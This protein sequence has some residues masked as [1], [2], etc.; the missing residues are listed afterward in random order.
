MRRSA[1]FLLLLLAGCGGAG[2]YSKPGADESAAS[3]AYR[4]CR[5]DPTPTGHP[6][7]QRGADH[8][9]NASGDLDTPGSRPGHP[10]ARRWSDST[11]LVRTPH[12]LERRCS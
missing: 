4:E 5:D 12:S 11:N 9:L 6:C 10:R 7:S 3:S 1:A 2:G 8:R